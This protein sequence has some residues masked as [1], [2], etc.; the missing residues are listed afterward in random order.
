LDLVWIAGVVYFMSVTP[1]L[2]GG[3]QRTLIG[4]LVILGIILIIGLFRLFRAI[5]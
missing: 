2:T 3:L 1:S 4:L 5:F